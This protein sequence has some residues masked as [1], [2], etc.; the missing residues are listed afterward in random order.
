MATVK[1][2]STMTCPY[3]TMEK[4][5]L[6]NKGVE[7]EDILVDQNPQQVQNLYDTCGSMGV[8][9]THI[10]RDDG[11]EERILGFDKTRID[12]ALGLA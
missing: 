10:I 6:K 3:C 7:Y 5:Y 9:C 1:V 8:P 12:S 11:T 4:D 2:Y